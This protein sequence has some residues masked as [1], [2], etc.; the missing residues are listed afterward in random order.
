VFENRVLRRI[1]GP[2]RD[3]VT[4]EWKKLHNKELHDLYSLPSIIRIIKSR[5]MRWAGHVARM[6]EKRNAYRYLVGR[7]EGK[8]PLGRPRRRW[9]DNI[10]M[11]LGEVGWGDVDWIGLAQDRNRWR[12]VV[13]SVLNLR[14]P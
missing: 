9:V 8:R 11:D 5:R 3:E 7:P 2:K 4:G 12:A 13:N 10:R 6:G 1:L 14:V